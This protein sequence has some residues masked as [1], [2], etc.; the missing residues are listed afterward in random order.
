MTIDTQPIRLQDVDDTQEDYNPLYRDPGAIGT[1][2]L[3]PLYIPLAIEPVIGARVGVNYHLAH[4]HTEGLLV[5]VGAYPNQN[6]NDAITIFCDNVV[7][8]T[9]LVAAD[10]NNKDIALYIPARNLSSGIKKMH[11]SIQ[12]VSE[13]ESVPSPDLD[14]LIK[15]EAPG[16]IDPRPDVPAHQLLKAPILPT[17][18]MLEGV[19][20]QP[21]I[22]SGFPVTI[23]AYEVMAEGDVITLSCQGIKLKHSVQKTD[24]DKSIEIQLTREHLLTIQNTPKAVFVYMIRDQVHNRSSDWSEVTTVALEAGSVRLPPPLVKGV[25]DDQLP[26]DDLKYGDAVVQV[27]ALDPVFFVRGHT[28]HITVSWE[29]AS[30]ETLNYTQEKVIKTLDIM[31]F[32]VPYNTLLEIPSGPVNVAYEVIN[33]TGKSTPSSRYTFILIPETLLLPAPEIPD[34]DRGFLSSSLL[35][36]IVYAGPYESM[37]LNDLVRLSWRGTRQDG[38]PYLHMTQRRVS[39]ALLKKRVPFAINGAEHIVGLNRGSVEVSYQIIRTS[40]VLDSF[41][42]QVHVGPVRPVLPAPT[43]EKAVNNELLPEQIKGGVNAKVATIQSLK[44]RDV[45]HFKLEGTTAEHSFTDSLPIDASSSTETFY[46]WLEQKLLES[47]LGEDVRL[48]YWVTHRSELPRASEALELRIGIPILVL[49]KPHAPLAPDDILNPVDGEKGVS[50]EVRYM[51]MSD[52]DQITLIVKGTSQ[53]GSPEI[54]PQFGNRDGVVTFLLPASAVGANIDS[55]ILI[56]YRVVRKGAPDQTS[57]PLTLTVQKIPTPEFNLPTPKISEAKD[58]TVLDMRLFTG[59]ATFVVTKWIYS[60]AGQ[61][62][63]LV[64][65]SQGFPELRVLNGEAISPNEALQGV[66]RKVIRQWLTN[67]GHGREFQV[68]FSV[69]FSRDATQA[70]AT[71]FPIETYLTVAKP[72]N[73]PPPIVDLAVKGSLDP[74]QVLASGLP[75]RVDPKEKYAVGDRVRLSW[76]GAGAN[77]MTEE[78][79][80]KS[81]STALIF[82]VPKTVVTAN[83]GHTVSLV[84]EVTRGTDKA[85]STALTIAVLFEFRFD[86]NPMALTITTI[87]TTRWRATGALPLG[88]AMTRTPTTGYPPYTYRSTAPHIAKVEQIGNSCQVTATRGGS[89]EVIAT[90]SR[91]RMKTVPV[92]VTQQR[93]NLIQAPRQ[94]RVSEAITW[95]VQNNGLTL[96]SIPNAAAILTTMYQIPNPLPLKATCL[97]QVGDSY[98]SGQFLFEGHQAGQFQISVGGLGNGGDLPYDVVCVFRIS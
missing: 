43:V 18:I 14:V 56:T 35:E 60:L 75:A 34:A 68:T 91:G 15:F 86:N 94:M 65:T 4:N 33:P 40:G 80:V 57:D 85:E 79:I 19:I 39:Q 76:K 21:W 82:S 92:S 30:G 61:R 70:Q 23:S 69:A 51:K 66:T 16:G 88:S 12:R 67:L 98:R 31:E 74:E 11:Y 45:L 48:Y 10:H 25:I 73:L 71:I 36:T 95:R 83:A 52:K 49:D 55:K 8:A 77:H 1:L 37:T 90:D 13:N 97:A 72:S 22:E 44:D 26:V 54:L 63:W 20:T 6:E 89:T 41:T 84:A 64:L 7:V 53:E 50:I 93:Y 29:A 9:T 32:L 42:E 96:N 78:Q 46:F 87:Q 38:G 62:C 81:T 27:I 17:E 5:L 24:V 47:N 59:D 28:V 2:A 3:F 58:T